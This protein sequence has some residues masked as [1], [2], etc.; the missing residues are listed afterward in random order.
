MSERRTATDANEPAQ[1]PPDTFDIHTLLAIEQAAGKVAEPVAQ[2]WDDLVQ[3]GHPPTA[4]RQSLDSALRDALATMRRLLRVDAVAVLLAG[5]AGDELIVRASSGLIQ[6][7]SVGI[8]VR[9]GEGIAGRVLAGAAP[10][11][12]GDLASLH[13][14][15]P[16]LRDSR[17]RSIA[18]V[19]MLCDG[20]PTGV[21]WA[22]RHAPD[23]LGEADAE[24]LQVLASRL[25]AVLERTR[26]LARERA[27]R[28]DAERL[29]SRLSRIQL[30]TAELA[31]THSA[32]DVSTA[33]VRALETVPGAW[34]GVWLLDD[35]KEDGKDAATLQLVAQSGQ[36]GEVPAGWDPSVGIERDGVLATT[37][38]ER[39]ASY[40]VTSDCGSG[41]RSWAALPI[42][43]R[44]R[45]V[46]VLVVVAPRTDWFSP[47]ERILLTLVV[48]QAGQA[49]ER[50]FLAD[51][52]RR[53]AE[54]A[55]FFARAAQALAEADD[56]AAT[57]DRLADL[58]VSSIGEICIIDVIG[59]D[60]RLAR[61][62]AKHRDPDR[63][64]LVDRLRTEFPPDPHGTHPAVR[65]ITTGTS[66][67]SEEM[68]DELLRATT[69]NEEHLALT[70]ALGFRSYLTVPLTV[71]SRVVGSVTCVSCSRRFGRGDMSF[72]QELAR[73]VASVVDNA[74]RYESAFRTSQI[75]QSSLLPDLPPRVG[76]VCVETRYLTAN[77]GLEVGGDFY[78]ML[79][80]PTGDVLFM[81]GDVAGHDRGAAAQMGHLRSA[82]RALAG[83]VCAPSALVSAV[84][85]AWELLG[86]E[87]LATVLVGLLDPTSGELRLA[88]AGHYPPLLVAQRGARSV[89]LIASP[90][91]GMEAPLAPEWCG[92]LLPGEVLLAYTDGAI[93]ERGAGSDESMARLSEVAADGALTPAGVCD[94][95]VEAIVRERSDDVALMALTID[96]G[97]HRA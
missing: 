53:A 5:D 89:P 30:A 88:S 47:E 64:S 48:G 18:A 76:G 96:Q 7:L 13:V 62:A 44:A 38:V 58:A 68:P 23:S 78:D 11:L 56:L 50:A 42:V 35:G 71:S 90:P 25:A 16:V 91:L 34:R 60:G 31:A 70:R 85:A 72:A 67:W 49:F 94:R 24:L 20:R 37:F 97:E 22:A 92:R 40:G 81:V 33:L 43:T 51:S 79:C 54:R 32:E 29:A 61:M 55:S 14:A 15:D 9:A 36:P 21:L 84:R 4:M 57:L 46:G 12:V 10:L 59:E 65:A 66:S 27:A 2:L 75:L 82:V 52:E 45:G 6:E 69:V 1:L 28:R 8:G 95:V 63:Q 19:P 41:E 87:R 26:A 86:F 83:Q 74:R 3:P 80:L 73:H 17:L 93:D 77:R 39:R